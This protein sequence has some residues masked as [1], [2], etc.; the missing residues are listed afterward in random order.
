MLRFGHDT[1]GGQDDWTLQSDHGAFHA[2][3]TPFLSFGVEDHSDSH[4]PSDTADKIDPA[5]FAAAVGTILDLVRAL[6]AGAAR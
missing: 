5:F 1:G 4:K 2:A 6:D 3:G